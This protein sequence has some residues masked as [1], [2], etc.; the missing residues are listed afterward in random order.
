M[1]LST[2]YKTLGICHQSCGSAASLLGEVSG[3]GRPRAQTVPGILGDSEGR[4]PENW[5]RGAL[6]PVWGPGGKPR[7]ADLCGEAEGGRT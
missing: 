1:S 3:S 4:A 6:P 5:G 2:V 7:T